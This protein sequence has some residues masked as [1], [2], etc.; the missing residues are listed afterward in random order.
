VFLSGS[1]SSSNFP[2]TTDGFKTTYNSEYNTAFVAEF[3]L[4]TAPVLT[5]TATT[6]AMR[7]S[8]A[9]RKPADRYGHRSANLRYGNSNGQR[10]LQH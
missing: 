6:V 7:E 5:A 2:V 8:E 10:G 9:F 3:N 1:T 4:G